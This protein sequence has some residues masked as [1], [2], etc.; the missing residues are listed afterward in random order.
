MNGAKSFP[1]MPGYDHI[2]IVADLD[3]VAAVRDGELGERMRAYPKLFSPERPEFG[4]AVQRGAEWRVAELGCPDPATA[5]IALGARLRQTA[6]EADAEAADAMLAAAA[7]LD[8]EDGEQLAKDEWEIGDRRYR[9]IRVE[10]FTLLRT[11][12]LEPPRAGDTDPADGRDPARGWLIDPPA[13]AGPWEAQFRL[14]LVGYLP[15]PETVPAA[16]ETEARHAVR[17]H[18]GVVL[19]PPSF[20]VIEVDGERWKP[21]TS[22]HGPAAARTMLATYWTQILPV[23]RR[24]RGGPPTPEDLAEWQAAADAIEASP[25]PDFTAFGRSFRMVRITRAVRV[26][27]DGPEGPRPTDQDLYG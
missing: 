1:L 10:K 4:F 22:G 20:T 7:R 25:G 5:R 24:H 13:P 21:F 26:G 23:L 11:G 17:T 9:V 27:R 8:P 16:A 6:R 15:P 3:P 19:L 18:P 2:Q 14:N 12:E